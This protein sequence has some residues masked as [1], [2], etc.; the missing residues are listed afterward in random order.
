MVIEFRY[1]FS[2]KCLHNQAGNYFRGIKM[3][4]NIIRSFINVLS[5]NWI[6]L[7]VIN[8]KNSHK[9]FTSFSLILQLFALHLFYRISFPNRKL[10]ICRSIFAERIN[11]IC[12]QTTFT[13]TF[14]TL[15]IC[16]QYIKSCETICSRNKISSWLMDCLHG[17]KPSGLC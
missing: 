16:P 5:K 17:H 3:S 11:I 7:H 14:D 6:F 9:Y 8:K 1:K 12:Y 15:K 13:L 4:W 10:L 2:V